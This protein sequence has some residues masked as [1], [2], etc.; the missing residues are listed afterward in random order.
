[1]ACPQAVEPEKEF[2]LLGALHGPGEFHRSFAARALE[3]IGSPDFENQVA[4]EG[5]HGFGGLFGW[6]GDEEDLGRVF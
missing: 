6:G 4:P 2:D 5:T 3:W 1:M